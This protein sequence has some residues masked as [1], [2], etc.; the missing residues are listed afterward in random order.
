M[1]NKKLTI[2]LLL[3]I[4]TL[5][6]VSL[7]KAEAQGKQKVKAKGVS[8]IQ[9]DNIAKA[10][11]V[12][13]DDALRRGVEKVVGTYIDSQTKVKNYQLIND[14]ILKSS[15]GYIKKYQVLDEYIKDN[16]YYVEAKVEVG[17]D[18]L[19]EDLRALKLNIKRV[20]NPRIM[21][22]LSQKEE[23]LNLPNS[24]AENE[25]ISQLLNSGYQVIDARKINEVIN[26]DKKNAI[27]AGD[28]FLA[29]KIGNRLKADL[30]VVANVL[31]SYINLSR[32]LQDNSLAGLVSYHSQI[33]AKVINV[34]TAEVM[35]AVNGDGKGIGS[36]KEDAANKSLR[37]ASRN[38]SS[39]IIEQLSQKLIQEP[40]RINL[41]ISEIQDLKDLNQLKNN[42][43]LLSG[44]ENVYFREYKQG[45]VLFDLELLN[46]VEVLDFALEL[47]QAVD[48]NLK[49]NTLN[50]GQLSLELKN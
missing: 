26:Y 42:L 25:L 27:L 12:A 38:I 4:F 50:E 7:V 31:A 21:V 10:R 48:F 1:R 22:L 37:E 34:S 43:P 29:A 47:Q 19:S 13:I 36:N 14:N 16:N 33:E 9:D 15:K 39:K 17:T 46:T 35:V 20:G 23:Y 6:N 11:K 32:H 49:V 28:L 30:V 2:V 8:Y 41:K 24:I 44:V 40:K 45:I 5:L 3:L 18:N